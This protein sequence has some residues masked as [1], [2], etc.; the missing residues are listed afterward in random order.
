M[1]LS[2]VVLPL[3]LSLTRPRALAPLGMEPAWEILSSAAD[4]DVAAAIEAGLLALGAGGAALA[5]R[6]L[7]RSEPALEAA[8]ARMPISDRVGIDVD[9]GDDGEP[10]G[11]TRLYFKPRLPRSELIRLQLRVP[12]GLVI[13]EDETNGDIVVTGALPGYSSFGQVEPGDLLRALTCYA[14]VVAGAPM[15][16]QVTSG[17]PMGTRSL[18]R[19]VFTTEGATF[20]DIRFAIASHRV[21]DG[22]DGSVTLI[23][24]RVANTSITAQVGDG[25]P[26]RLEPLGSIIAKDLQFP[27]LSADGLGAELKGRSPAERAR[28]LLDGTPGD[29]E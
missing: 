9:L 17:T 14:E 20:S 6:N 4:G 7:L 1:R 26:A 2:R 22:G 15:W 18:K 3:T 16:Q 11:I 13:E 28:A 29:G 10:R 24:E 23:L 12:L 8:T 25:A 27:T 5:A 21:D 19:L